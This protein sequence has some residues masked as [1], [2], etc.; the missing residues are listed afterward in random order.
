MCVSMPPSPL[1]AANVAQLG[2]QVSYFVDDQ[3]LNSF[4]T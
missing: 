2:L 3:Y 4:I 1:L